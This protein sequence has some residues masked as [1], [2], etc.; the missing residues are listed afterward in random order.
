MTLSFPDAL[1]LSTHSKHS[2]ILSARGVGFPFSEFFSLSLILLLCSESLSSGRSAPRYQ[3]FC[4]LFLFF[5]HRSSAAIF[6]SLTSPLESGRSRTNDS[7][8]IT[9]HARSSSCVISFPLFFPSRRGRGSSP[10]AS[11]PVLVFRSAA[12]FAALSRPLPFLGFF[13]AS[14]VVAFPAVASF[15][16]ISY[17]ETLASWGIAAFSP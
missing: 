8:F 6:P 10:F 4:A 9:N 15:F 13:L 17:V 14:I 7:F 11:G 1:V 12:R 2:P 3:S 16:A 5:F